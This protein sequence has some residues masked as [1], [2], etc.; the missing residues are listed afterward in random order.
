[1]TSNIL[2]LPCGKNTKLKM[3]MKS[4]GK[5]VRLQTF[6]KCSNKMAIDRMGYTDHGFEHVKVVAISALKILRILI[7][8]GIKP[9]IVVDY[10][11]SNDDAEIIVILASILHD[12]GMAVVR[13]N[14]EEYSL[15]LSLKFIEDLL[16]EIYDEEESTIVTSETLHA[17]STHY[18][19]RRP[20]TIEAGVSRVADALDMERDRARIPFQAGNVTIHSVS[21][22]SI[23]KVLIE[24]GD[25][26]PVIIRIQMTGSAGI[27]QVDELLRNRIKNS[28]IEDYIHVIAVITGEKEAKIVE[29]F[30][31]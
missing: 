21:A 17:I 28:G 2:D 20:L 31:I 9:S 10:G 25:K 13:E 16:K 3:L 26:K 30:E 29:R 24:K 12:L 22:L 1:L 18:G 7:E 6:W 8:E 11:M 5:D 27:F 4:I 14:H 15:F 19:S 23:E